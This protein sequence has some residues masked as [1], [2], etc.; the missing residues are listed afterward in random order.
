MRFSSPRVNSPQGIGADELAGHVVRRVVQHVKN[1]VVEA[2]FEEMGPELNS[3]LKRSLGD[4]QVDLTKVH[5]GLN[6]AGRVMQR[7][8]EKQRRTA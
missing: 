4:A 1:P 8:A 3:L 6:R 2:I 7:I 5:Q